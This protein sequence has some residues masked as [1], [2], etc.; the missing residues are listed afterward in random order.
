MTVSLP[1][2]VTDSPTKVFAGCE[3]LQMHQTRHLRDRF[4]YFPLHKICYNASVTTVYDLILAFDTFDSKEFRDKLGMTPFHI[5]ATSAHPRVEMLRCLLD[6]YPIETLECKDNSGKLMLDYL[7]MHSSS[8]ALPLVKMVLQRAFVDQLSSWGLGEKWVS[9]LLECLELL[10]SDYDIE[11]RCRYLHDSFFGDVGH[12]IRLEATSLMELALWKIR[13]KAVQKE[14]ADSNNDN[15]QICRFHCGA[16]VA[17]GNVTEYLWHNVTK[18]NTALA[19]FQKI[20]PSV[21]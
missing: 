8:N 17:I 21:I 15:R 7:M 18:P 2:S 9:S 3:L 20:A 11:A 10:N 1:A 5:V 16:G 14:E 12:C 4:K 19:V 13:I 6:K